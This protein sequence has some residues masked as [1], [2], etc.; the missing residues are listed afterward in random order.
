MINGLK[1]LVLAVAVAIVAV[2]AAAQSGGYDGE[3]FVKAIREDNGSEAMKLLRQ[4]PTLVNARDLGGKSAL[5]T[6]I[7]TRNSDWTLYLLQQGAD[8]NLV[9]DGETPLI[10]AA[11]TGF[12]DAAEWLLM[13]KARVDEPNRMGETPL[14]IAVQRRHV[15]LVRVLLNAGANPDKADSAAGYSARDYARRDNRTPELLRL[16][17]AK[18]PAR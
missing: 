2:P 8:P 3:M 10:T 12:A 16:I 14:I 1:R 15:P 7:E 5:A 18:K 11:R 4:K 9:S 6:A 17:E 13:V